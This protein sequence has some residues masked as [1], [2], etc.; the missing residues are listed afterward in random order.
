M[1]QNSNQQKESVEH[2]KLQEI[3][4]DEILNNLKG[5]KSGNEKI[6]QNLR[7]DNGLLDEFTGVIYENA[8]KTK[9]V[10]SR[11]SDAVAKKKRKNCISFGTLI[12]VLVTY[13]IVKIIIKLIPPHL[14]NLH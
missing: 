2:E 7:E 1:N 5:I 9:V 6:K 8:Q 14:F 13:W 3:L 10:N 4:M 12:I 11:V